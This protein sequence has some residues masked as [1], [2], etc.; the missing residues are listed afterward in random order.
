MYVDAVKHQRTYIILP[1]I[2][3]HTSVHTLSILYQFRFF[4]ASLA[5]RKCKCLIL[6][7]KIVCYIIFYNFEFSSCSYMWHFVYNYYSYVKSIPCILC[8]KVYW[9][10]IMILSWHLFVQ[11]IH[12]VWMKMSSWLYPGKGDC[13]N[14]KCM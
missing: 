2:H 7:T 3:Q 11:N 4:T 5:C 1:Y 14:T 13:F 12:Y 6:L 9:N 8:N 10:V